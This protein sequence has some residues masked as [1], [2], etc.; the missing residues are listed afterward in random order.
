M[1]RHGHTFGRGCEICN[2]P[3]PVDAFSLGFVRGV[4]EHRRAHAAAER[5]HEEICRSRTARAWRF[6][7][8]SLLRRQP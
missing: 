2:P 3:E 5:L 8:D 6:V 4:E 7:C 1:T